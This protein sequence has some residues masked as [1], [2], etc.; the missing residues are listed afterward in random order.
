MMGGNKEYPSDATV[1]R[2]SSCEQVQSI[3]ERIAED[4]Q[5]DDV[6][7]SPVEQSCLA[8]LPRTTPQQRT[9]N[10]SANHCLPLTTQTAHPS[11]EIWGCI[12]K[13]RRKKPKVKGVGYTGAILS[14]MSTFLSF[15]EL[16]LAYHA[17]CHY[18]GTLP[19]EYQEDHDLV[20][21]G[22]RTL[23]QYQDAIIYRGDDT[24][25]SATCKLHSQLHDQTNQF[26]DQMGHNSATGERGLK[27]WAKFRSKMALKH[28]RDKFTQ[29]TSSRVSESLLVRRAL[30][31]AS[32][33]Q[34]FSSVSTI[35]PPTRRKTAHFRFERDSPQSSATWLL[36][37][38]RHGKANKPNQ[39]TGC[40]QPRVLKAIDQLE[41]DQ[42]NQ[43]E[44]FEIWCEAR[45]ASGQFVRCWP[46]YRSGEGSRYDWVM[47]AF[48]TSEGQTQYPAKVI[49]LYE[50]S[51]DG[52]FKALIHSVDWKLNTN[53]EGPYGDSRL[54]T[55]YRLQF[56]NRGD[57]NLMSV[58]FHSIVRCVVGYE[59]IVHREPLIPRVHGGPMQK[60]Y[61]VMIIRPRREWAKL[62]LDWMKELRTRQQT[63]SGM[64][65]NRLDF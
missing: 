19:R 47:V 29:S 51:T 21:F 55:H 12:R 42:G 46:Q 54:V 52:T 28:G 2:L 15:V 6:A 61:T 35:P 5:Q 25:D 26:G 16:M 33:T 11:L 36:S 58:P 40:I 3:D 38:D 64:N 48:D 9:V 10:A 23:V 60:R 44:F 37:L 39:R 22:K 62:Y 1:K 34:V 13:H 31:Q 43:Q 18:S 50:D 45:L 41:R 20:G 65:K 53:P 8:L 59:A 24:V 4:D 32:R 49:A 56:D 17:W 14:D 27:D 7:A 30:N 57:P 63:I